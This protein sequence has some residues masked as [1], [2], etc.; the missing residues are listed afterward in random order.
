MLLAFIIAIACELIEEIKTAPKFIVVWLG[1]SF[2]GLIIAVA[3]G[4]MFPAQA[5][6]IATQAQAINAILQYLAGG[7]LGILGGKLARYFVK[8]KVGK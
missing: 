8:L 4:F 1:S 2:G 6:A 7:F 5:V 3:M